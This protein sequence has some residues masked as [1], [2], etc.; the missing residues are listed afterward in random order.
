MCFTVS[1][2]AS[3]HVVETAVGALFEDPEAYHP[4]FHV[5][6]FVHPQLPLIT[7]Q[8]DPIIRMMNWGLVPRWTKDEEKAQQIRKMT[9][10]ARGETAFEKP[11]YRDAIVKRR[12]LLPV[13]GFVEWR[14]E[15]GKAY[16]HYVHCLESDIF[17][18][19]CIWEAWSGLGEENKFHSFSILTTEAN[20]LMTYIHNKKHRM[21]VIIDSVFREEWLRT[22][23]RHAIEH[24]ML[25]QED[26]KLEA[27][28]VTSEVSR[29]KLNDS[30]PEL[31]QPLGDALI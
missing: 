18:L 14:H 17:T 2:Y 6:G 9:L 4:F 29:I 7:A 11:S 1:I 3:T 15:D 23:D 13:Q 5:S 21:P 30:H 24:M 26:G 12:G 10:N 22:D 8:D 25:P 31:L 16:P 19:G 20:V 27:F 28:P